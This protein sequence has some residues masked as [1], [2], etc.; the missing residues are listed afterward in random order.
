MFTRK[1]KVKPKESERRHGRRREH[2]H[3]SVPR[4]NYMPTDNYGD[5]DGDSNSDAGN[6]QQDNVAQATTAVAD[7]QINSSDRQATPSYTTGSP[8]YIPQASAAVF[9]PPYIARSPYPSITYSSSI[10]RGAEASNSAYNR[11]EAYPSST[12]GGTGSSFSANFPIVQG[13]QNPIAPSPYEVSDVPEAGLSDLSAERG[14]RGLPRDSVSERQSSS[15]EFGTNRNFEDPHVSSAQPT[16]YS[17][18][19]SSQLRGVTYPVSPP[20]SQDSLETEPYRLSSGSPQ[21]AIP[22]PSTTTASGQYH[23]GYNLNTAPSHSPRGYSGVP[24]NQ[25]QPLDPIRLPDP[26]N[27]CNC[28][29]TGPGGRGHLC[30]V[31]V[32]PKPK[33][34]KDGKITSKNKDSRTKD[35]KS[36]RRKNTTSKL[37]PVNAQV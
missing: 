2:H 35:K 16:R 36:S 5:D 23:H 4:S 19:S 24:P 14:P 33:P 11:N 15:A 21:R 6:Y 37:D 10:M 22:Q 27:T 9:P 8:Q 25:S 31:I 3:E 13:L 29:N 26:T 17:I 34:P 20:Y 30:G 18:P 32:W 7:M 28:E 1:D 12:G